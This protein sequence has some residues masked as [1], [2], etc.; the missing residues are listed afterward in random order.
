MSNTFSKQFIRT[1]HS[2]HTSQDQMGD[3]RGATPPTLEGRREAG[4][5][6]PFTPSP[7]QQGG[8]LYPFTPSPFSEKPRQYCTCFIFFKVARII[9]PIYMYICVYIYIYMCVCACVCV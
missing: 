4:L 3:G 1:A 7:F 9:H 5:L 8:L 6:Y 2:R